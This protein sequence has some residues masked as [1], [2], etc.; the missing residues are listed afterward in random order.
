MSEIKKNSDSALSSIASKHT[1]A[2]D[3]IENTKSAAVVTINNLIDTLGLS[4][5]GGKVCQR[6]RVK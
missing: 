6:I 3:D 2:I 1:N 5:K 4:V